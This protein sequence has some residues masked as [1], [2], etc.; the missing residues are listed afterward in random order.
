MLFGLMCRGSPPKDRKNR[1]LILRSQ[2]WSKQ[3][4]HLEFRYRYRLFLLTA[5]IVAGSPRVPYILIL[6]F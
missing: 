6:S 1:L 4:I 5:D 3:P 2:L